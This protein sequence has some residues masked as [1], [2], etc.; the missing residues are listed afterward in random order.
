MSLS[1]Q[2][3]FWPSFGKTFPTVIT[4]AFACLCVIEK[5]CFAAFFVPNVFLYLLPFPVFYLP[6]WPSLF[7]YVSFKTCDKALNAMPSIPNFEFQ[8]SWSTE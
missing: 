3:E 8:P 2:A 5:P 7:D 6:F 4:R 1:L